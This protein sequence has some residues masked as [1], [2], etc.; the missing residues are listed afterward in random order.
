MLGSPLARHAC[1]GSRTVFT[2]CHRIGQRS[3]RA[4]YRP[5]VLRVIPS[6]SSEIKH[7]IKT[8]MGLHLGTPTEHR[9]KSRKTC[10]RFRRP[11]SAEQVLPPALICRVGCLSPLARIWHHTLTLILHVYIQYAFK[12]SCILG[13]C[14]RDLRKHRGYFCW[15]SVERLPSSSAVRMRKKTVVDG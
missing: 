6:P 1:V 3:G 2:T 10:H 5:R 12:T 4:K 8:T 14:P 7:K 11:L 9:K 13:Y 15:Q